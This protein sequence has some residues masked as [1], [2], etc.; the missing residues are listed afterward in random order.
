M[1]K[2]LN[3]AEKEPGAFKRDP[4]INLNLP[5]ADR[6]TRYKFQA[7]LIIRLITRPHQGRYNAADYEADDP[8]FEPNRL[9]LR[10]F[11]WIMADWRKRLDI[12]TDWMHAE[13]HVE[14]FAKQ[15]GLC[16]NPLKYCYKWETKLLDAM[17]PYVDGKDKC[18]IRYFAEIMLL[19]AP[20][21]D[22]IRKIAED[23]DRAGLAVLICVYLIN[24]REPVKETCLGILEGLYRNNA[25]AKSHAR[26]FLVKLRPEVVEEVEAVKAEVNA[27]VKTD[28]KTDVTT[29]VKAE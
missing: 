21:L 25:A 13:W 20:L 12:A 1:F 16:D 26:K 18:I 4:K 11:N 23:P 5:L 29:D 14:T 3:D 15:D 2:R 22:R 24:Y 7:T 19:D 17:I 9:R 28:V 8:D 10:L 6:L 27:D